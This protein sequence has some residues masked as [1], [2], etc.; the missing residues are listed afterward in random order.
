MLILWLK[1]MFSTF[2]YTFA[3]KHKTELNLSTLNPHLP[4][5]IRDKVFNLEPNV[6][7]G[8]LLSLWSISIVQFVHLILILSLLQMVFISATDDALT[9]EI[10][11]D[12]TRHQIIR[13]NWYFY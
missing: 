11:T 3:I 12:Q 1:L 2:L 9:I 10:E 7:P 8:L 13:S 5:S 4:I 6:S